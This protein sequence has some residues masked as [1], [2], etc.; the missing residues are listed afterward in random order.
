MIIILDSNVITADFKFQGNNM[1]ILMDWLQRTDYDNSLYIPMVVFKEII[2]NYEREIIDFNDKLENSLK[3]LGRRSI[4]YSERI[5]KINVEQAVDEYKKF[6]SEKFETMYAEILDYPNIQ[7]DLI[8][9]KALKKEKPFK[10]NGDGFRDTL[11]WENIIEVLINKKRE[12]VVF[13]SLNNEDFGNEK[14]VNT[15][16]NDLLSELEIKNIDS[17]RIKYFSN[18]GDFI[19]NNVLISFNSDENMKNAI[20]KAEYPF[21]KFNDNLIKKLNYILKEGADNLFLDIFEQEF[22]NPEIEEIEDVYNFELGNIKEINNSERYI[23]I[24]VIANCVFK[25]FVYKKILRRIKYNEKEKWD[26]NYYEVYKNKTAYINISLIYSTDIYDVEKIN[27]EE[28]FVENKQN[29]GSINV[30]N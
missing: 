12:E 9:E 6:L 25:G 26:D 1:K 29:N 30:L 22:E 11:I 21:E 24:E 5:S 14:K 19:K 3:K 28:M 2:N 16:H 13:I 4:T 27:I 7:F 15:L 20:I 10:S 18:F 17:N 23:P 8:L